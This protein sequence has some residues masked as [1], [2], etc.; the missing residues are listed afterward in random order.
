MEADQRQ[1]LVQQGKA[2]KAQL[3]ELEGRLQQLDNRLQVCSWSTLAHIVGPTNLLLRSRQ[4]SRPA[5]A[6]SQRPCPMQD[7]SRTSCN[8]G[9]L[10]VLA[11][12][13]GAA[14]AKH[15]PPISAPGR[16]GQHT[17][18]CRRA[19]VLAPGAEAA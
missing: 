9:L 13:G 12:V 8:N 5:A 6:R 10:L 18:H 3:A 4:A 11:A 19:E 16:G 2:L 1:A 17:G 15:D 7:W 14:A